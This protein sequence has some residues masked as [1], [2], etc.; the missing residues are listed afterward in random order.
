MK[1][2]GEGHD[3]A[4]SSPRSTRPTIALLIVL[5]V[6]FVGSAYVLHRAWN[7]HGDDYW[8]VALPGVATGAGTIVLAA[9][10]VWLATTE[11]VR[12]DWLRVREEY[13]ARRDK[14]NADD[15]DTMREARKVVTIWQPGSGGWESIRIANAGRE[16]ILEV[17]IISATFKVPNAQDVTW[18]WHPKSLV[19]ELD[20]KRSRAW[21]RPYIMAGEEAD[22]EGNMK[23]SS[24][25]NHDLP[26]DEFVAASRY[27][28]ICIAWTD[29]SGN[30]WQRKGSSE[31]ERANQ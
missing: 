14:R 20:R 28:E 30:H 15:T 7:T 17:E 27:Y 9:V 1:H 5:A 13:Q 26:P 16:S 3:D 29:A 25:N 31:P 23:Y 18:T 12:S 22:F 2:Q 21:Y 4:G 6:V 10:T 11:R 8:T 24:K 19:D